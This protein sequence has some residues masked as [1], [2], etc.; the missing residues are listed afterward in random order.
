MFLATA[1]VEVRGFGVS[2]LA[3]GF[4]P[5]SSVFGAAGDFVFGVA[6]GVVLAAAFGV[7]VFAL[8]AERLGAALEPERVVTAAAFD[9]ERF[10]AVA[11][12]LGILVWVLNC[13]GRGKIGNAL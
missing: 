1:F 7:G 10:V 3:T 8:E 4:L 11:G 9:P 5:D 12:F 6:F 2:V 13:S